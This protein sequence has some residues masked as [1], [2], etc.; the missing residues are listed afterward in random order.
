MAI[1]IPILTSFDPKGMKQANAAFAG[2]QGSVKSL[3]KNFAIAGAAIGGFAAVSIKA[4][5]D[6]DASL[7]KSTAIM[8]DVSN[9]MRQQMSTAAR[10]VAKATTFS[11]EQAA[12]AYFFLASAGLDAQSSIAALPQVAKFAQAGMFDMALATDLLTDAQS[13]LGMVIKGDP[14]ANLR[15][16]TRLSDVLVKANTLAN[17]SVEQFSV[18]LTTK[19]GAALKMVNKDVTEGVAVL[20]AFADQG[21]KGELAG[22]QFSIVM[23]DLTT[24]AIQNKSAFAQAGISVFDATGKMNNMADIVGDLEKALDGM[25][26]ETQKATLL[27]LGF[28]D[29]SLASLSALLGTSDAIR[30][31]E[32]SLRSAAG[33]TDTVAGKQLETLNAQLSLLQSEFIDV[34]ISIGEQLEPAVRDLV[35]EVK[36]LLPALGQDLVAAVKAVNW[37]ELLTAVADFTR[38]LVYNIETIGKVVAAIFI[39]NTAFKLMA[40]A[41]GIAKVAIA[42]QTW[43]TAQLAAGM[44]V[45]TVAAGILN[46]AMRLIPFVA[47]A[48]AIALVVV[49]VMELGDETKRNK[50]YVDNYGGAIRKTGHDAEWAA[51]RYAVATDAVN[52]YNAAV[53]GKKITTSAAYDAFEV[54]R[55]RAM[56]A[57]SVPTPAAPVLPKMPDLSS[58]IGSAGAGSALSMPSL[59]TS[60]FDKQQKALSDALSNANDEQAEALRRE[61]EILDARKKAYESFTDS[62]KNLFGQIKDS[63]MSSFTLPTLGNS[64]NSITRNISKLLERTKGFANSISR[65]SGMGLNSALLQQVIQAGPMQGS[66]LASALVG[67]GAGFISQLNRAYGEFGDLA[68]GIAGTGTGAAFGGQQTIN[69]FSIEVTGGLAT[70]SDVGRAVVNAIKDYERQSGAAW[71]A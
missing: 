6:F 3:G 49:G 68:G 63:I 28:S 61:L 4:F 22:T 10:D 32:E 36:E 31:Y 66:K 40:V 42:L 27:Q 46:V 18:A 24:K 15:E 23:R 67:G 17:A 50:P 58:L 29:K 39:L 9:E 21:I 35:A 25:S 8:G 47:V 54:R 69:N 44:T 33:F 30:T 62:V 56:V 53:S 55:A 45:A 52:T 64:V 14:L 57:R 20:A 38:F 5:A 11:A 19:A 1:K 60:N 16:M 12:E 59:D 26:D 2:L 43:F 37:K 41:S 13:A 71:R 7:T 51:S 34:G 65:L 48:S 70:G